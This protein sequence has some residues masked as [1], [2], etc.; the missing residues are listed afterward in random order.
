MSATIIEV[1]DLDVY[2]G[3]SQ[4]L[5]GVGLSVRQGETMA[6][7]GRNGAGKSTTMKAIM[8]LAPPRRGRISLRGAVIS[9]QRPHHIARA[10]LGFVPEDRQIFP[11]HTVEDNLVIGRKKGPEGQDEW[12]IRRIYDVFPLLEPLRHRIAGR[13][14]GGE[15]QMLAIARTL[16]GNPALLLLDEPSEGLAPIIV[17]RIGELLRQ[18]RQLGSTV[19]IA[20]QNMHFCLGLASH[21][22]V[23]DKGQIVYAAGIDD[24]K[25]NDAIRRRYLAL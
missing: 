21:A 9:G 22:T 19:L 1:A 14:S 15:Q 17:Q 13:L 12:P 5:F 7:L 18:L 20:E 8:G 2:Y 10:G 6:L 11:E 23:I 3:T 24:L 16:M 25:A 4:I